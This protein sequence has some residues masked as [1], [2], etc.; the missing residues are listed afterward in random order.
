MQKVG[1]EFLP[2]VQERVAGQELIQCLPAPQNEL[3]NLPPTQIEQKIRDVSGETTR[4]LEQRRQVFSSPLGPVKRRAKT[5]AESGFD[6]ERRRS[7]TICFPKKL[8]E[9]EK[10]VL[11][12]GASPKE[13]LRLSRN[14]DLI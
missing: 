11:Y 1:Q 12:R 7:P 9:F 4:C 3:R 13:S 6:R 14:S 8:D 2:G 5:G 10:K